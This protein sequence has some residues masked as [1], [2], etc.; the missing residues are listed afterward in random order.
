LFV[1]ACLPSSVDLEAGR[2]RRFSMSNR[3]RPMQR[4]VP[5]KSFSP[6]AGDVS[7]VT[8]GTLLS[9]TVGPADLLPFPQPVAADVRPSLPQ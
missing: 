6:D 1:Q 9:G 5:E 3:P 2:I 8:S 4:T 7:A